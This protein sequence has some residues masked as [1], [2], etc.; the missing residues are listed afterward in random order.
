MRAVVKQCWLCMNRRNTLLRLALIPSMLCCHISVAADGVPLQDIATPG[1]CR[2]RHPATQGTAALEDTYLLPPLCK[3]ICE[4]APVSRSPS[5]CCVSMSASCH[6]FSPSPLQ[7][8][9]CRL[10]QP[11]LVLCE[12]ERVVRRHHVPQAIGRQHKQLV[13]RR[14]QRLRH[15]RCHNHLQTTSGSTLVS[16]GG[17]A[18]IVCV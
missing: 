17:C 1:V 6:A 4:S 10:T 14:Q 2:R 3:R 13:A 7:T 5:S 15:A 18:S 11:Q 16:T 8:H 12:H 9:L